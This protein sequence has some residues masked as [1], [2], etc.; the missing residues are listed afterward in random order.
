MNVKQKHEFF[1]MAYRNTQKNL[2]YPEGSNSNS[3]EGKSDL[4]ITYNSKLLDRSEGISNITPEYEKNSSSNRESND[5][6]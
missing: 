2:N 5:H 6:M 4:N 1:G 3:L